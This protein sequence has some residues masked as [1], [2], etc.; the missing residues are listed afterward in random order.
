MHSFR[1]TLVSISTF[2]VLMVVPKAFAGSIIYTY[3]GNDFT[4]VQ[5]DT[6]FGPGFGPLIT[7]SDFITASFTFSAPLADGLSGTGEEFAV[8][9]WIISD[10]LT[11]YSGGN[12]SSENP[13]AELVLSTN[14]SGQIAG[15]S[16]QGLAG[17]GAG[18][19]YELGSSNS[20]DY[21]TYIFNGNSLGSGFNESDPGVWTSNVTPEPGTF[22][23]ILTGFL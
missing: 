13:L 20:A 10:Q 23:L 8:Q 11:T 9:S 3:T 6:S 16:F 4:T 7:T 19:T 12:S 17:I 18:N 22:C 21:A 15:W 5:G 2:L 14:S 1:S